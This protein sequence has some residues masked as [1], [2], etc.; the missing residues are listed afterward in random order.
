MHTGTESPDRNNKNAH[1]CVWPLASSAW[2]L[3]VHVVSL[4]FYMS[5]EQPI[6]S[7]CMTAEQA[8]PRPAK[9]VS[10]AQINI[11]DNRHPI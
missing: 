2:V 11:W 7:F 10:A 8:S 9:H 5:K 4:Y 6:L 1:F 3:F